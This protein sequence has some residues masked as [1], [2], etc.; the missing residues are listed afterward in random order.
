MSYIINFKKENKF[1]NVLIIGVDSSLIHDIGTGIEMMASDNFS[2]TYC[3]EYIIEEK[4]VENLQ[5]KIVFFLNNVEYMKKKN[6]LSNQIIIY[7]QGVSKQQKKI[8]KEEI[9]QIDDFLNGRK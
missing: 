8:L 4:N 7:R 1:K 6:E 5:F 2:F 9:N 3:N